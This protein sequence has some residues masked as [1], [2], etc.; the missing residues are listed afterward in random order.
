[1]TKRI[2]REGKV[3]SDT[4]LQ[5]AELTLLRL[6]DGTL[7]VRLSGEWKLGRQLPQGEELRRQIESADTVSRIIFDSQAIT[8]WDSGL[9]IFLMDI[10]EIGFEM[11]IPVE[12]DGLPAG[13]QRILALASAVP[14]RKGVRREAVKISFLDSAGDSVIFFWRSNL[15]M[16]AFIEPLLSM[17]TKGLVASVK[18][19][20]LSRL[21]FYWAS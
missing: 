12:K 2:S 8:A 5:K 9:M 1:M 11:H 20:R 15:E 14:E 7:T 16:L 17:L 4:A 10:I 19:A 13:V 3:V 6:P 18:K 21:C